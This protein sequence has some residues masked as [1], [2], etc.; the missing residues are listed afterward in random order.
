MDAVADPR[1]ACDAM[2]GGLAR[3]LRAAGYDASW[4][5]DIDDGDLVR[6][7]QAQ[8]RIVLSSDDDVFA[9]R[10][11]RNRTVPALFVPRG[12]K[13]QPQLEHVLHALHLS[14][15]KPRCMACSGTLTELTKGAAAGHG[16]PPRSLE[17]CDRF[18]Q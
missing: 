17:F 14:L 16:V 5:A 18:W 6:Q 7:A 13:I 9:F 1:F 10:I 8:G 3:W 12:L 2:L 4:Q 15:R 11:I